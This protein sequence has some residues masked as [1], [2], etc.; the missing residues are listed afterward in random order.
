VAG[1]ILHEV[2]HNTIGTTDIVEA[3]QTMYG[4]N[5]CAWLARSNPDKTADNADNYRLFCEQF[6]T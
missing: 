5:L 2:S 4:P 1:V 3:G 6:L